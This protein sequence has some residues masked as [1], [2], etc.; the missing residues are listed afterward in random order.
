MAE[1]EFRTAKPETIKPRSFAEA[2]KILPAPVWEGHDREIEMYWHAWQI[3]VG[4]IR[5]PQEDSGFVSPYLDIAYNGNIFMWDASFMMMFARYGYRF[6]PFQRTLDNFYAKQHPD[7]FI[8]REI[9]AD[10]SDCF[11]RYDP[12]STGPNLLPWVELMY[13]RQFGDIDRLHKVFPAL[14]AYAK[15]WRLNRT[16]PDGTYWSSGW[17]TGMDNMPRVKPEYNPIFSHGHMVWLDTNLQQMLVDESL[18][19]IGF[20]I[21][22]W[23]EIEDMEDEMKRLRAYVNEHLWDDATGFLYDRYGDGSLCTTKGI[24]AFWALQAD[25][26]DKG[27]MDRMVA[28]LADTAEFD[29]PHR[30]PS[31]SADHPKY[32]P[33]GRYWQGGVWPGANYMVIDGLYRKGYHDLALEVAENHFNAVFEVWKNTGTFW[34]YYA[35]EKIEPGF[36]ARKDFVG[37]AGLPPIAVFIE[38]ILGIKSDYSEGRIVWDINHTEAH[39]ID[40][41]DF[42]AGLICQL[43]LTLGQ[44]RGEFDVKT[45]PDGDDTPEWM[46]P[47]ASEAAAARVAADMAAAGW[48]RDAEGRMVGVRHAAGGRGRA[49]RC[50][51]G[52]R[53]DGLDGVR[54]HRLAAGGS[55]RCARPRRRRCG[56]GSSRHR[57]GSTAA[58]R[59]PGRCRRAPGCRSPRSASGGSALRGPA[60]FP[61]RGAGRAWSRCT[62]GATGWHARSST[63]SGWW[64]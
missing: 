38:Y 1:N 27:R 60:G 20:H 35:P 15:W 62:A 28:H 14:C 58:R 55:H 34:E 37:W 59:R 33:T 49:H 25:A 8:C 30:V 4:N 61:G 43:E 17:G 36:M 10:G 5:Q 48:K 21:E 47:G 52:G 13:Y 3:A 6:F 40:H 63:A 31:L 53:P 26:L 41:G 11:E 42:T 22:R 9:R 51:A 7:G 46:R 56:A 57:A 39:G 24:G 23:Q 64:R 45:A 29:R 2:R 44:L 12:T 32:N 16:W 19:N 50:G 54:R 18:L